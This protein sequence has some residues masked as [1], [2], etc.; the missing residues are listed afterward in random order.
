MALFVAGDDT[1]TKW[2]SLR[3]RYTTSHAADVTVT[4]FTV[5][6]CL[7]YCE[8]GFPDGCKS[9][10]Y[11]SSGECELRV[12]G[13]TDTPGFTLTASTSYDYYEFL[14]EGTRFLINEEMSSG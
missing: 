10:V 5:S 12:T 9:V 3:N 7:S 8:Q 1:E 4:G 2:V 13:Q 6:E 14:A 11:K